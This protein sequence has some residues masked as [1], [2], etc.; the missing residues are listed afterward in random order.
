MSDE[1]SFEAMPFEYE[2]V[3]S[4]Q[5]EFELEGERGGRGGSRSPRYGSA[6]RVMPKRPFAVSGRPQRLP[7]YPPPLPRFRRRWPWGAVPWPDGVAVEPY[8]LEP[9]PYPPAPPPTGSE[10]MRWVQSALNDVLGLRL[11]LHGIADPATQSAIR[12]FQL[13]EGLPADGIV[14]PDTERALLAARRATQAPVGPT[15]PAAPDRVQPFEAVP[16]LSARELG[17]EWENFPEFDLEDHEFESAFDILSPSQL[18]AVRI[19]STFETGRPGGFGGLTGNIDGQGLSFGLLNF[20]IRAGSLIPL[21]KEF[22]ERYPGRYR[23]IFGNDADRFKE[24]VFA[25]KPDSEDPKRRIRDVDRQMAFVNN[26]MNLVPRK[27]RNN[28]IVE[29][30]RT[31]FSRLERD[32][33]FRKVQVKAVRRALDRARHWYNYFVFRTERGFAFMFDIVSS[34]GGAWLNAPK[35][36]GKRIALL[37]N[38]LAAKKAAVGRDA[39]TEL[40][41]MDVIS[42]MIAD[43]SSPEWRERVRV[44]KLWFVRGRGI[45]HG[46]Q[47]DIAKN[48]GITDNPPDFG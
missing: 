16:P 6:Q 36:K 9:E 1:L 2:S 22:I 34:H 21:L 3:A 33:E 11:P 45:V 7:V 28:R 10:Y 32:P 13:R 37:R 5:M 43:V 47:Y 12:S 35:F 4:E 40:E 20:T 18:K 14:G 17:F 39:L 29:P 27:A 24:M 15:S 48:F 41:K 44:R 46:K 30:W 23:T 25:T 42:N 31:Y 19:T 26:Q 8:P 38:M